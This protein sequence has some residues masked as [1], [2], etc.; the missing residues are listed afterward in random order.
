MRGLLVVCVAIGLFA[1]SCGNSTTDG[2][3]PVADST[4]M[5]PGYKQLDSLTKL[6]DASPNNTD[7]LN[8]RAKLFLKV[9]ELNFALADIG[10]AILL[11]SSKADYFLTIAD[12]YFQRNEPKLCLKS[13]EVAKGLEP[14]NVEPLYKLA[15]FNLY[16]D[17]HQE[18]MALAND[19]L[20]IDAQDDRPFVIKA[21]C[22]KAMK[23]TTKAIENYMLAAEQNPDNFDAQMELGILHW[24]RKG[25]MA[26]SFLK[27]ALAIRPDATEALY[28]LGV[29][30]QDAEK[31]DD[32]LATYSQ[33]TRVDST[34]SAAYFNMGY[35]QQQYLQNYD[36]ALAHF[37][38]AAAASP[39]YY[40]AI[41]MRGLCYESKGDK[42][43]AKNEYASALAIEPTY[44]K[45]LAGM[46]RVQR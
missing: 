33:L 5:I 39:R 37:N 3:A 35:I 14:K 30:Y 36:E 8:E 42:L 13:L 43:K 10:R 11:D 12:V 22:Y 18:S 25:P 45:A 7:L 15:Q 21:L 1:M 24:A 27:N 41:Y 26:E 17:K 34:Y 9:G 46:K 6:L 28:A 40:Q 20:R 31:L 23:D 16:I 44:D 32:A 38:K 19:M 4:A 29:V 2:I